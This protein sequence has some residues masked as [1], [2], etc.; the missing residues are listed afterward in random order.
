[1]THNIKK[2]LS[3]LLPLKEG[4]FLK[5]FT[6]LAMYIFITFN[7]DML[8]GLKDIMILQ[9]TGKAEIL[10]FLKIYLV[11]PSMIFI[12]YCYM[13]LG[14]KVNIYKRLNIVLI[15]FLLVVIFFY[16]LAIPNLELLKLDKISNFLTTKIPPLKHLWE[17]IRF[18]PLSLLYIH[19]EAWSSIVLSVSFWG[20]AN[21]IITFEQAG[22]LYSFLP[23][24]GSSFGGIFAGLT[25]KS[26]FIHKNF[27]NGLSVVCFII[28]FIM[29]IYNLSI[30]NIKPSVVIEP[31]QLRKN[32]K[33][34]MSFFR[35][36]K[37]LAKSKNL[38]LIV[39]IVLSYNIFMNLFESIWK[40]QVSL[41]SKSL[42]PK[43]LAV[44]FGN[45]SL[46]IGI[47][48]FII[49]VLSPIVKKKGWKSVALVTPTISLVA[50][51]LF[52][53]FFV[54]GSFIIKKF[55][56]EISFNSI[57][58]ISVTLGLISIVMMKA[59]KYV[60]FESTKEQAYIPLSQEEKKDG[61]A[62]IDG[63]CSRF[64]KSIGGFILSAPFIGLI[65]IFGTIYNAKFI[66]FSIL[67]I[68]ITLW[69]TSIHKLNKVMEGK[70]N[71]NN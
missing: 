20:L 43:Y 7:H 11:G 63:F 28:V 23:S 65:Q 38:Q 49:G 40:S 42:G 61:K 36:I 3:K 29:I 62:A 56:P 67:I 15:Y 16:Y 58:G 54:F 69:I 59:S 60:L 14:R 41:Y 6:L 30:K 22:R 46:C 55:Y 31:N 35:S 45:Q 70:I 32:S 13:K 18:W 8:H 37:V 1:M 71:I 64:G 68:I 19:G 47:M 26:S 34:K 4:E 57:L 12:I 51:I 17:L 5:F 48:V 44:I 21:E 27:N 53:T 9:N 33:P 25:L 10:P 52:S 2:I 24:I 39:I 50:T 66:I